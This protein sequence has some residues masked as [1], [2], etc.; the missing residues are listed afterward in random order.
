[1]SADLPPRFKEYAANIA[2]LFPKVLLTLGAANFEEQ[3][4]PSS[5]QFVQR[6]EGAFLDVVLTRR[7]ALPAPAP[8]S[9]PAPEPQ[10]LPTR[11]I[12][13]V[14]D[15]LGSLAA[16]FEGL[17]L[18]LSACTG[19][20]V[21]QGSSALSGTQ[22]A[23]LPPL[24][25]PYMVPEVQARYGSCFAD[26][27]RPPLPERPPLPVQAPPLTALDAYW[28]SDSLNTSSGSAQVVRAADNPL[29]E[30]MEA[31]AEDLV[32]LEARIRSLSSQAA[33][34]CAVGSGCGLGS[35]SEPRVRW[36]EPDM[37]LLDA[38]VSDS[39]SPPCASLARRAVVEKDR[40]P[41]PRRG[42]SRQ[43]RQGDAEC[44]GRSRTQTPKVVAWQ[45]ER[46]VSIS[47][48]KVQ[49]LREEPMSPKFVRPLDVWG[50]K[51]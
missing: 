1:M 4:Q 15:S 27:M 29:L 51:R 44:A 8:C 28:T 40:V 42:Q 17:A 21:A 20:P 22:R 39:A 10:V 24:V 26:L 46:Q 25:T 13:D 6:D 50:R 48:T 23:P 45:G 31:M 14:L 34:G 38:A 47:I 19:V 11:Q 3:F 18:Q 41:T 32:G 35:S 36:K 16:D 5:A 2:R 37:M 33:Q 30:R 12:E 7:A 43:A 9:P 49:Q